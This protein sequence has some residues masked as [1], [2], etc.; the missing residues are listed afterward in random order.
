MHKASAPPHTPTATPAPQRENARDINRRGFLWLT[1]GW[2]ATGFALAAGGAAAIRALIPNVLFE[3]SRRFKAGR[4]EDYPDGAMTFIEEV[5]LSLVREGKTFRAVS[6]IC[7][8]L[9]CTVNIVGGA[10]PFL[11][12]CHG[13]HF[14]QNGNVANGPSPRGLTWHPVSLSKDGHLVIDLDRAVGHETK[15]VVPS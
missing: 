10:H 15:L 7:P 2:L 5:R 3:P 12:P 8:H 14:D 1:L 6:A 9:G 11:C 13:S 4:P